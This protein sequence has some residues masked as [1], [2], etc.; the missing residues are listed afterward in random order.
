MKVEGIDKFKVSGIL[1]RTKNELEMTPGQGLIPGLWNQFFTGLVPRFNEDS[2]VYGVYSNYESDD[3]GGFD[4]MAG[5]NSLNDYEGT[6]DIEIE[7]GNYLVF[8]K[9]GEMPNTVVELWSEIWNYFKAADCSYTRE[10][11]T[12]FE[13]Y[14]GSTKVII[15]IGIK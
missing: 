2:E 3:S 9:E 8:E 12:D 10:Y 11:K 4:V 6:Q 5:S 7:N 13:K 1:I 15:Y 14:I